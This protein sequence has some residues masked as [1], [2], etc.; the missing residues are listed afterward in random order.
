MIAQYTLSGNIKNL[1]TGKAIVGT[2][3]YNQQT[4]EVVRWI[5]LAYVIAPALLHAGS[6]LILNKYKLK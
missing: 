5:A 3:V 6:I 1:D 4:D 2:E